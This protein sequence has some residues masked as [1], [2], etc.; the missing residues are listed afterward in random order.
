MKDFFERITLALLTAL[1][2]SLNTAKAQQLVST[3]IAEIKNAMLA[4]N[5]NQLARLFDETVEISFDG[6]KTDYSRVQAE[7][8][9]RDFFQRN[10]PRNFR[11]LHKSNAKNGLL[12]AV[13][14]YDSLSSAYRIY[15]VIRE[16][17]TEYYIHTID[18]SKK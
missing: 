8:V 15:V 3:S 13:A 6:D 11:Y 9:M 1:I 7:F 2:F 18:I 14:E 16:K 17:D 12:Y 4:A 10:A 5:S